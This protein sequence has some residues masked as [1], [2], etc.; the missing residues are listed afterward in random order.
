MLAYETYYNEKLK[1]LDYVEFPV[2][3]MYDFSNDPET[4]LVETDSSHDINLKSLTECLEINNKNIA[5]GSLSIIK[6][7][8]CGRYFQL[9]RNEALSFEAKGL[10]LPKR[11]YKCRRNRK[12]AASKKEANG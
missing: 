7:K 10:N 6:C 3:N 1:K 4:N 11:C 8:D 12:A 5:D 9:S 2:N